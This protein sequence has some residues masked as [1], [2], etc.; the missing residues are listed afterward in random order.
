MATGR[1]VEK[2]RNTQK[3]GPINAYAACCK[4]IFVQPADQVEGTALTR[5]GSEVSVMNN[6]TQSKRF[7]RKRIVNG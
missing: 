3:P 4:D 2:E 1:I 6:I 5:F 7:N